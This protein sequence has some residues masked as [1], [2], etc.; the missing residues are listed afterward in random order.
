MVLILKRFR[1]FSKEI[2]FKDKEGGILS[3]KVWGV[4]ADTISHRNGA[5]EIVASS[6]RISILIYI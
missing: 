2:V 6:I 4:T 1:K 5:R 3:R